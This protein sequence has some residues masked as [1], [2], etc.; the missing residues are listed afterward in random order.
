[1]RGKVKKRIK[2]AIELTYILL[3][4]LVGVANVGYFLFATQ[5]NSSVK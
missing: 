2:L 3:I 5:N 4:L 1:M